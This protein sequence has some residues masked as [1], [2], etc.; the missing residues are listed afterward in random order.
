MLRKHINILF[1]VSLMYTILKHFEACLFYF[2][3]KLLTVD[4]NMKR[5]LLLSHAVFVHL[6]CLTVIASSV[7]SCRILDYKAVSFTFKKGAVVY[8]LSIFPPGCNHWLWNS[9]S[10][11]VNYSCLPPFK[12]DSSCRCIWGWKKVGHSLRNLL[13]RFW[14][15]SEI[16]FHCFST[17]SQA[18]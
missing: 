18:A 16:F 9:T 8:G 14:F 5:C 6:Y 17:L 4:F 3:K 13:K 2:A 12:T 11:T 1:Y 10:V 7:F 15:F